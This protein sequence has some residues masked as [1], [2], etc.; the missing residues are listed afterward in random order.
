MKGMTEAERKALISAGLNR[1]ERRKLVAA[2]RE[3][4]SAY[5]AF[6]RHMARGGYKTDRDEFD[7]LV[8]GAS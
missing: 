3:Q 6:E 7:Q 4:H 1:R 8:R 2:R 5:K